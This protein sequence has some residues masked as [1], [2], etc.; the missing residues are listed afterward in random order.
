MVFLNAA[1]AVPLLINIILFVVFLYV[2]IMEKYEFIRF[3]KNSVLL[4]SIANFVVLSSM[5]YDRKGCGMHV[6]VLNQYL[7][8][9]SIISFIYGIYAFIDEKPKVSFK[10]INIILVVVNII[11][12]MGYGRIHDL[13]RIGVICIGIEIIW[14]TLKKIKGISHM[15]VVEIIMKGI[16]IMWGIYLCI[17]TFL[18]KP[19]DVMMTFYVINT[20]FQSVALLGF[21]VLHFERTKNKLIYTK[22]KLQANEERLRDIISNQKDI[23]FELNSDGYIT[24]ISDSVKNILNEEP[25]SFIG[26]QLEDTFQVKVRKGII[27]YNEEY[28]E[29][30]TTYLRDDGKKVML[31]VTWKNIKGVLNQFNGAIG[32]IRDITNNKLLEEFIETDK[33]KTDFFTDIS[34]DLRTPLNVINSTL[35]VIDVYKKDINNDNSKLDGYLDIINKNVYR[36]IKLVNNLIDISKIDSGFYKINYS[37]GNLVEVVED[38][39]MLAVEYAK[40]KDI[41]LEFDTME[42]EIYTSFDGEKMERI[43]LNLLSNALKFTNPGGKISVY[44]DCTDSKITIQVKDNGIGIPQDKLSSIFSKFVQVCNESVG[45]IGSGLGLSIVKSLVELQGGSIKV[46][47]QLGVGS[48]FTITLPIIEISDNRDSNFIDMNKEKAKIELS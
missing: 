6:L 42:E 8:L 3:W 16:L 45:N 5:M 15:E 43:I 32:S 38:T 34:H 19:Y 25:K 28:N 17:A 40:T 36:L 26:K 9:A 37:Y 23:I 48:I 33:I 10:N 30:E 20:L 27:K 13:F 7:T 1:V 22:N 39:C 21:L 31:S 18:G 12:A 35:Q 14:M 2:Y 4:V 44:M 24:F 46:E 11:G 41:A 29:E 47:S